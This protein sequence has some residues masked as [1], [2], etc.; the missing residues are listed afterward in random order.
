[1]STLSQTH[2]V[3]PN[4]DKKAVALTGQR[5]VALYWKLTEAMKKS[6]VTEAHKP[7]AVSIPPLEI[8]EN[9]LL[10]VRPYI[11]GYFQDV[12]DKLIREKIESGAAFIQDSDI[13]LEACV[14]Y[15]TTSTKSNHL[16]REGVEV[17]FSD[18]LADALTVAFAEKLGLSDTPSEL[19]ARKLDTLVA[20]YKNKF[21]SLASPKTKY[22][23]AV[24]QNLLKALELVGEDDSIALKFKS[25]LAGMD[26]DPVEMLGL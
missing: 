1:M 10:A 14:S 19:E 6:G 24:S 21:A 13:S 17:W 5:L 20:L 11:V 12:Q 22:P 2:D 15:L 16:T 25:R 9:Q 8:S 3:I 7:V 26:V 4:E 23:K 18:T